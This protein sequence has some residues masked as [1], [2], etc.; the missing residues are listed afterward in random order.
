MNRKMLLAATVAPGAMLIATQ[1]HAQTSRTYATAAECQADL[2]QQATAAGQA[3]DRQAI[4]QRCEALVTQEIVVNGIR[5]SVESAA[6]RKRNA[7][8]IVDSVV[9]E[10]VGKLPDNNVPEALSRVTG[11]Q[12]TRE[13]GQGQSVTIRGMG[14]IQTTINGNSTNLGDGRAVNLADIPAELLK[15]VDVY[16]TRSADQVEG[17]IAGTVNVELRRPLDL[18]RGL[19]VAG[20]IRGAYDDQ[21]DKVSPYGSL[22]VANRWDTGIGEM[23]LLVNASWTRNYYHETYIESES[24]DTPWGSDADVNS[25]YAGLPADAKNAVMPYRAQYGMEVGEVTRPS[26]NAVYQWRPSDQLEFVLEGGYI[27]S[28]E[29]R[30]YNRLYALVREYGAKFSDISFMPDGQTVSQVTVTNANGVP[31]GIDSVYNTFHSDLYTSNFE[32]HWHNDDV[33]VNASAQ[34]NKSNEGNYFVEQIV[35]PT[36]LTS[37]T[38]DFN[39]PQ[40]G[41]GVPSIVFN[42][43]DMTDVNNYGVERFQDNRGGSDNEEFAAQADVTVNLMDDGLRNFQMGARYNQR[44][45]ARWYGYRDGFPRVN[46]AYAPLSA[47]PGGDQ[48]ALNTVDMGGSTVQWYS[49]PGSVLLDNIDAIRAYVQATDPGNAARFASEFPPLDLGQNFSSKEYSFAAYGQFNYGFDVG[50]PIDGLFGVRFVN[51]WGESTS[52][53]YRLLTDPVTNITQEV[54]ETGTGRGNYTDLLPTATAILHFTPKFQLRLSYSTNVFRPSFYDM[55]PF[56][57]VN[58]LDANPVVYAGNPNL[59]A[60]REYSYDVSAEYYFG[61]GGA[62]TLAGYYKHAS[63]YFYYDRVEADDLSTYGLPGRSGYVEQLRNAGDGTFIGIEGSAQSFFDFLPGELA[64]FGAS[65]NASHIFKARVEWPYP[66]DF[67]G[68]FDAVG[69]SKW[70][71]NAAL[72]YDTPKFS[73]RVAYNYRSPYRLFIW[74]ARPEYSFYNDATSRLDVALN[75]TPVK[76]MTLSVEGTNLLGNDN[77]RYFGKDALLPLGVRLQARTVQTSIRFRF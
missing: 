71:V 53:N 30:T 23:G 41:G 67:P 57:W 74:T 68:A 62:I 40:Y 58:T 44:N 50:I 43:I 10:D 65:V 46:G 73:A 51:T 29:K 19:T 5:G 54:T 22:L 42:G 27:G 31:A 36:G 28:R 21:S 66:E 32:V 70:T 17:G 6:N 3:V 55:R 45:T 2:Q 64:N 4:A 37:M 75:Y 18:E 12:I 60:Q 38:I 59:K 20:S 24:P 39:S 56:F 11:V 7:R 63:N 69:A 25:P 9:A 26:V 48:A 33:Q 35:R 16:K 61:R 34:Y 49:I 1:A 77:Y 14:E 15:R 72:F 47:F 8:Q 13:R 52:T 76:F